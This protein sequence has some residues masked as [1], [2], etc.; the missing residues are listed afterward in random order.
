MGGRVRS[1]PDPVVET[2]FSRFPLIGEA[3]APRPET[4][5]AP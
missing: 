4:A 1:R 2:W 5:I 3:R